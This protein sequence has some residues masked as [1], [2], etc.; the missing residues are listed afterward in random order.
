MTDKANLLLKTEATLGEG[1]VWDHR[2]NQLYWVDIVN[3]IVNRYDPKLD[4]NS[5]FDIGQDV[6]CIVP[7]E[8]GGFVL[9]VREGLASVDANINDFKL[10]VEKKAKGIRFNDGKCDLAGRFWVGT[11]ADDV[12]E[13]AASLYCL[14]TDLSL[15]LK[16]PNVTISNGLAWTA[17]NKKLFYIDTPTR[18]VVS[19]DYDIESGNIENKKVIIELDQ[20]MGFPDG[21]TID[22]KG[23]LY[24][25]MW[26]GG[27]V[28]RI[29]PITGIL[30]DII[31]VPGAKLVTSCTFGGDNLDELFITTARLG[32]NDSDLKGQP[33][34]GSLFKFHPG[35]KGLPASIFRG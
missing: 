29:N 21:M 1:P 5:T 10:I 2:T 18:Q 14:N 22:E 26:E 4:Q 27:K 33:N 3:K 32:L 12:K 13:G 8:S 30:L 23:D 6:S 35:V 24:V 34:A 20:Q 16:I 25:S 31:E 7:R 9:G 11:I 28:I 19:Y 17:D 15:A